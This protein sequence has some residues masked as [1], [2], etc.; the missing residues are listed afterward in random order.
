MQTIPNDVI[1]LS[2]FGPRT[3][4]ML[5]PVG[6]FGKSDPYY[7]VKRFRRGTEEVAFEFKSEYISP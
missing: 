6:M 7:V 4:L 3:L 2:P 5:P 1:M